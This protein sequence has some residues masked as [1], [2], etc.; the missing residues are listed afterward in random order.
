MSTPQ[1]EWV[2]EWIEDLPSD[3]DF[4]SRVPLP[5]KRLRAAEKE[6]IVLIDLGIEVEDYVFEE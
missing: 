5:Q 3:C 2:V 6:H 1:V 4:E